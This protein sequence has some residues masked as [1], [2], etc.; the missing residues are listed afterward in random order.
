MLSPYQIFKWEF[1]LIYASVPLIYKIKHD[2]RIYYKYVAYIRPN[3]WSDWAEIFFWPG[4]VI[5]KKNSYFFLFFEN[6]LFFPRATPGL[7]ASPI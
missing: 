2:I 1:T 6:C 4:G 7:S 3:G 5:G